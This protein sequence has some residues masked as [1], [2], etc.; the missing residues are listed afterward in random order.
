LLVAKQPLYQPQVPSRQERHRPKNRP[1]KQP[2]AKQDQALILI[3][4]ILMG[5]ASLGLVWRFTQVNDLDYRIRQM[6][7]Q[8]QQ[9]QQVN[10]SLTVELNRLSAPSQI[11]RRASSELG[12]QWPTDQQIVNVAAEAKQEEH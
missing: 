10:A 6:E 9:L 7:R 3:A 4:V 2:L 5:A 8:V 12:M 1:R 11:E